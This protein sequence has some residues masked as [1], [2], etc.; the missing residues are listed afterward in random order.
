MGGTLPILVSAVTRSSEQLGKRVSG[1]YWI[2]TLGAVVGTLAC[3]FFLLPAPGL[4][5]SV[6]CAVGLNLVASG[7][8]WR[9]GRPGAGPAAAPAAAKS[10]G[11]G[12]TP[13][14][15]G[16]NGDTGVRASERDFKCLL[17]AFGVVGATAFAYEIAWTRLLAVSIGSSTYGFT[18]MLATFLA[19]AVIGSAA[20]GRFSARA[21]ADQTGS[22]ITAGTFSRTQTLIGL[23]A[24]SSL[25]LFH[26]IPRIVPGVLRATHDTFAGLI[27][28]Q[29]ATSALTVL[30]IAIAF[31]Y[32]FPAVV[33]LLGG[34]ERPAARIPR[35][36]AK[37]TRPTRPAR[38]LARSRLV[39][40]WC[41]GWG[42]FAR[43][44]RPRPLTYCSLERSNSAQ[45]R[46]RWGCRR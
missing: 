35:W 16:I 42:V 24:I 37:P 38:S 19:G 1:L 20:F 34:T 33:V 7:L 27:L 41:P 25:I 21:G 6:L 15:A 18:I 26:W 29:F 13:A 4:H 17:V 39:S 44:R 32:N 31:G 11:R 2:N 46:G 36:S 3:G 8:A 40:G 23:A 12:S 28:A 10:A 14:L 22:E 5:E 30:P 9:M 43:S 45:R